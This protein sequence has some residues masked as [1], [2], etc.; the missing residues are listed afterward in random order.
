MILKLMPQLLKSPFLHYIKRHPGPFILGIS[1]LVIT[2]FLD[3]IWP[4]ILKKGIALIE[5]HAPM[6][7][8]TKTSLLFAAPMI[9]PSVVRYGWRRNWGEFHS[10]ASEQLRRT[11]FDHIIY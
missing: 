2:N 7:D 1:L 11:L 5:S 8:L 6:S 3:S 10:T 4:L 9:S